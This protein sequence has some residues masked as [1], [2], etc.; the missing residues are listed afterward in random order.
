MPCTP[1]S[2]LSCC[3]SQTFPQLQTSPSPMVPLVPALFPVPHRHPPSLATLIAGSRQPQQSGSALPCR[4]LLQGQLLL[5]CCSSCCWQAGL[6][7]GAL[8]S[9]IVAVNYQ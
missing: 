6:L 1:G 8:L 5:P 7:G 3:P 9:L 4:L 2:V